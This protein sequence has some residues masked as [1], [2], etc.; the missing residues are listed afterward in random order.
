[1]RPNGRAEHSTPPPSITEVPVPKL[2]YACVSNASVRIANRAW[3]CKFKTVIEGT[4]HTNHAHCC[5][6][7]AVKPCPSHKAGR[8]AGKSDMKMSPLQ[9]TGSTMQPPES[10]PLRGSPAGKNQRTWHNLVRSLV[11]ALIDLRGNHLNVRQTLPGGPQV[12]HPT[13]AWRCL[14]WIITGVLVLH[15]MQP[16]N[17]AAD[18]APLPGGSDQGRVAP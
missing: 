11:N 12:A 6:M 16:G 3:S 10:A 1:M 14:Q 18:A 4:C 17:R 15:D 2:S 7:H 9:H 13:K 5:C 8:L